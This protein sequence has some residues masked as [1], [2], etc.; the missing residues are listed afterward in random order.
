MTIFRGISM[1]V[2]TAAMILASCPPLADEKC[3]V[4]IDE[5][6]DSTASIFAL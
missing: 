6:A 4:V 3:I 2:T 5:S 1:L